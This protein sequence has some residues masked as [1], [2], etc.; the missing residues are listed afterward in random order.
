[1]KA[2]GCLIGVLIVILLALIAA[3][4]LYANCDKILE[5]VVAKMQ[6]QVLADLPEGYD[7]EMVKETFSDFMVALREDRV[8][9]EEL[10]LLGDNVKEALEDKKLETEE[11][12][13]LM[14]L[15]QEASQ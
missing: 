12:D 14:Q 1:M 8:S 11:V 6:E 5:G 2:K 4:L 10:Q 13:K 3:Y 7:R 15:M 9:K